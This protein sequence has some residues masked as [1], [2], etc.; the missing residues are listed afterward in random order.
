MPRAWIEHATSRIQDHSVELLI[1]FSLLLS[2]LSYL[3]DDVTERAPGH[4]TH[5]NDHECV[6]K[7]SKYGSMADGDVY[8]ISRTSKGPKVKLGV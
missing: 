3:G 4:D 2:Q 6:L 8:Q 5:E 1:A 7:L